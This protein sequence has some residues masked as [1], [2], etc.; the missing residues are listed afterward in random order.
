M[1]KGL[2][3]APLLVPLLAASRPIDGHIQSEL[4]KLQ[5]TWNLV[6]E[7]NDGKEMSAEEAKKT[8]VIFDAE[9]KWKVEFDGKIVAEGTL[10]LDPSKKPKTIAYTFTQGEEKGKTFLAIYELDGDSFKH[11]GVLQGARPTE[12]A[13][14]A[15]SGH[16]LIMFQREKR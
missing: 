7:I 1:K 14:Q 8:R 3:A 4:K 13:S 10:K 9:G 15:G 2:L 5:G 11:C 12:F 6:K 16:I